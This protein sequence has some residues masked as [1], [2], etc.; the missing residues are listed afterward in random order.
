MRR[1]PFVTANGLVPPGRSM[2]GTKK[3]FCPFTPKHT[4]AHDRFAELMSPYRRC[5]PPRTVAL[6]SSGSTHT[7][8]HTHTKTRV[9]RS[10]APGKR[11]VAAVPTLR[12]GADGQDPHRSHRVNKHSLAYHK[13]VHAQ[14]QHTHTQTHTHAAQLPPTGAHVRAADARK[15]S[16]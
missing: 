10:R 9:S 15:D 11:P 1:G 4:H 2:G 14:T 8:T 13:P 5:I 12:P 16:S 7:R 3:H 6:G